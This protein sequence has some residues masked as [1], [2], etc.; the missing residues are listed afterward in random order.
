M[1]GTTRYGVTLSHY[2]AVGAA[3]FGALAAAL[4]PAWTPSVEEAWRCAFDLVAEEMMAGAAARESVG[5]RA[6]QFPQT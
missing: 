5:S 3:L 6:A 4:G 2:A 1:P